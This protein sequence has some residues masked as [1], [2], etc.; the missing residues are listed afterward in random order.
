MITK[1]KVVNI[2]LF[3]TMFVSVLLVCNSCKFKKD[4]EESPSI[5]EM[6]EETTNLG[7]VFESSD[8]LLVIEAEDFL[9]QTL[10]DKRKWYITTS[11]IFP[12]VTPDSDS[13]HLEGI[14]GG[15]YVEVLPDTR[16][17]HDDLMVHGENFDDNPGALAIL[18]YKVHFNTP[19]K[20]YVWLRA[21]SSN[22]EDDSYHIG[23]D[24]EWPESGLR[25]RT[26][27][28]DEWGWQ[29]LRRNPPELEHEPIGL[30]SYIDVEHA[31]SRELQISM[32]EDGGEID[33]IVLALDEAYVPEGLGPN[34]KIKSE[35]EK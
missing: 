25:W 19:G 15:A 4:K 7:R 27:I 32:R 16:H 33:K 28:N 31:G 23:L 30:L 12:N 13:V 26:L 14:S 24:D 8:G 1:L 35:V 10:T 29:R 2:S 6:S 17:T 3:C 20:Y 18:H 21:Y 11:E 34:V 5:D 9:K 22:S